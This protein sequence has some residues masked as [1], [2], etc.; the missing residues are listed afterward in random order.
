LAWSD[1]LNEGLTTRFQR[2]RDDLTVH[3]KFTIPICNQ[4]APQTNISSWAQCRAADFGTHSNEGSQTAMQTQ[5]SHVHRHALRTASTA[6]G[7]FGIA[8]FFRVASP[9]AVEFARPINPPLA[10]LPNSTPSETG[11]AVFAGGCFWGV[12][13]VFQHTL[14]VTSA[15]SGY[16]GGTPAAPTYEQ[17]S[18][19]V[20]RSR[21]PTAACCRS[22]FRWRTTRRS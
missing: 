3:V 9:A 7:L 19:G 20:I 18:S 14:G 2:S 4:T 10:D 21:S 6:F 12:Q 16:A 22:I 11:R 13:A 5:S 8:V 1:S 17:V 15:V